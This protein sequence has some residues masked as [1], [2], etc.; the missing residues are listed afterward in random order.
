[1]QVRTQPNLKTTCTHPIA[2]GLQDACAPT[3][4]CWVPQLCLSGKEAAWQLIVS[5]NRN[6]KPPAWVQLIYKTLAL[7]AYEPYVTIAQVCWMRPCS[8]VFCMASPFPFYTINRHRMTHLA[9]TRLS[10]SCQLEGETTMQ[11]KYITALSTEQSMLLQSN[12]LTRLKTCPIAQNVSTIW[13]WIYKLS[14]TVCFI[15]C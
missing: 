10:S 5:W 1:M 2:G 3:P 11:F 14:T 6:L 8:F 13:S 9:T 7:Q 4:S 15:D 12:N